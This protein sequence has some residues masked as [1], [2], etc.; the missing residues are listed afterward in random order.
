MAAAL[1]PA[2]WTEEDEQEMRDFISRSDSA[3]FVV[4]RGNG[5]LA[6]FVEAGTR[7][8][9]DGCKLNPVGYIEAWYVDPDIRRS[10][11]GRK[12]IDAAED[13]AREQGYTEMASDALIDNEV[14]H[15]AH[16]NIGYEEVSRVITYRKS[17]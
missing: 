7:S 13:W 14:S 2:E 8:I 16:R 17:L 11:Y 3:V 6:G 9:A 12:L 5:S 15:A 10:G 4:D 1:F